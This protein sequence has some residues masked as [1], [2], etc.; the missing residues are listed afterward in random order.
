MLVSTKRISVVRLAAWQ[1]VTGPEISYGGQN[2]LLKTLAGLEIRFFS[3]EA[4]QKLPDQRGQRG[5]PLRRSN[6][7]AAVDLI[8]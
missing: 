5:I 6:P 2:L 7:G 3:A 1:P 8:C 4:Q